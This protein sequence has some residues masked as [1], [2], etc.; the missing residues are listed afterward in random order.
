[1]LW[2]DVYRLAMPKRVA[3]TVGRRL[4]RE[5]CQP[6]APNFR[7]LSCHNGR[8][9]HSTRSRLLPSVRRHERM[10]VMASFRTIPFLRR[11]LNN[12]SQKGVC[13]TFKETKKCLHIPL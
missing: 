7:R 8:V 5:K 2:A 9:L 11:Y 4:G 10:D 3:L 13:K 12:P 6:H 1:M